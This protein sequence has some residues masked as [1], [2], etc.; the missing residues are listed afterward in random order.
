M[1]KLGLVEKWE[2]RLKAESER[3]F[4]HNASLNGQEYVD[5]LANVEAIVNKQAIVVLHQEGDYSCPHDWVINPREIDSPQHEKIN[6]FQRNDYSDRDI[7]TKV[8]FLKKEIIIQNGDSYLGSFKNPSGYV[9]DVFRKNTKQGE[10]D[11]YRKGEFYAEGNVQC[12]AFDR[13]QTPYEEHFNNVSIVRFNIETGEIDDFFKM[14]NGSCFAEKKARHE[15]FVKT[16]KKIQWS[17]DCSF[18]KGLKLLDEAGQVT[19]LNLI[20][21]L[22]RLSTKKLKKYAK[23]NISFLAY[24]YLKPLP[25]VEEAVKF[26]LE[27]RGVYEPQKW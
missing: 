8:I 23:K 1:E 26:I 22:N 6:F 4:L 11:Y 18:K 25:M 19:M 20:A 16:I 24:K 21:D 13:C 17:F 9:V 7:T 10:E 5:L 12:H 15:Y 14:I 27:K 3:D 2:K